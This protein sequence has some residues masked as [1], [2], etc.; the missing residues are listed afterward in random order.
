M[1][2]A[3]TALKSGSQAPQLNYFTQN[4]QIWLFCTIFPSADIEIWDLRL[5]PAK[6]R[7]IYL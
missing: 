2:L 3:Q 1:N 6:L 5:K 4:T 7:C